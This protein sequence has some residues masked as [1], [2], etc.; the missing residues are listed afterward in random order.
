MRKLDILKG[1]YIIQRTAKQLGKSENE[2]RA[3]LQILVDNYWAR[4]TLAAKRSK[5]I[6][7]PEGKPTP[8]EYIIVLARHAKRRLRLE[9]K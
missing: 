1:A 7:F 9:R 6:L 2:V 8:D 4:E 3:E 5:A